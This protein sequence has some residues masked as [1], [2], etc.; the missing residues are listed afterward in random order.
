MSEIVE[1]WKSFNASAE[2]L[3]EELG[4]TSNLVGEYAEYLINEHVKGVL[5]KAS[6]ASADIKGEDDKLYQVKARKISTTITTQLSIIRSW[7]FDYLAVILFN[8]HGNVL[9]AIISPKEV[10]ENYA[11]KNNH[12]NGWVITT[13]KEF[14]ND[15]RNIDITIEVGKLNNDQYFQIK[16]I[17]KSKSSKN[18]MD[19]PSDENKIKLP[20]GK[21]VR[22]SLKELIENDLISPS[23]IEKLQSSSY[24]KL[25]FDIQYPFFLKVLLPG[26]NKIS[27]Y[28]KEPIT[29]YGESYLVCSEWYESKVN[30]DRPYYEKWYSELSRP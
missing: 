20:I 30:N 28:W 21:F 1:L 7:N 6:N 14:L 10:S 4:R 15:S 26:S 16:T 24:S 27:R 22:K 12:Q 25:T 11:I 8:K 18:L 13:T 17:K 29:I 19:N 23:E 9:K 2:L 3:K 5:L